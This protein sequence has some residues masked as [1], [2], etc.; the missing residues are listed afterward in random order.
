[1][2][3]A[4]TVLVNRLKKADAV[5]SFQQVVEFPSN[6]TVVHSLVTNGVKRK[7][8]TIRDVQISMEMLG[9]RKFSA[10]GKT[11]SAQPSTS[12]VTFPQV[13]VPRIMLQHCNDVELSTDSMFLNGV[14]FLVSV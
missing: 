11:T 9:P 8:T 5:R 2:K 13:C 14:I 10:K 3:I 4:V 1:M 6:K 7:P 12:N